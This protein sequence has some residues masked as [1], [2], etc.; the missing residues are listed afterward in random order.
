[1]RGFD[2]Q[3]SRLQ[4]PNRYFLRLRPGHNCSFG[5]AGK[6]EQFT[7]LI[8]QRLKADFMAPGFA[9]RRGRRRG[10]GFFQEPDLHFQGLALAAPK[11]HYVGLLANRRLSDDAGKLP[12]M[13]HLR[14]RKGKDEIAL[15]KPCR[16]RRPA[17]VNAG[18]QSSCGAGKVKAVRQIVAWGLKAHADP[19]PTGLAI[20]LELINDA[21]R[22][23]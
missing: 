12:G 10:A 7:V 15:Q 9:V 21:L 14:S 13:F 5:L 8:R 3:I 11:D 6:R 23:V 1:M 2:D 4:L 20:T 22:C 19:T 17:P 16:I 18:D